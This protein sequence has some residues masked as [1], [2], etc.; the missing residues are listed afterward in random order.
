MAALRSLWSLLVEQVEIEQRRGGPQAG[1]VGRLKSLQKGLR[2]AYQIFKVT[3]RQH[4]RW[5]EPTGCQSFEMSLMK[6]QCQKEV[7]FKTITVSS[8]SRRA[9][10]VPGSCAA[11]VE[12]LAEPGLSFCAEVLTCTDFE[13]VVRCRIGLN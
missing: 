11:L 9:L 3:S 5:Q 7:L 12:R 4:T 13:R 10:L 2:S 8:L 1:P 6:Q